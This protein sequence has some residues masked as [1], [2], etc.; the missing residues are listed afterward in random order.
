MNK[1]FKMLCVASGLL[2]STMLGASMITTAVAAQE[3]E[4][5]NIVRAFIMYVNHGEGKEFYEGMKAYNACYKENGGKDSW[6]AWTPQSGMMNVVAFRMPGLGWSAFDKDDDEAGKAC[7]ETFREKVVTHT[8]GIGSE[9]YNIW[10]DL[11]QTGDGEFNVVRVTN[12]DVDSVSKARELLKDFRQVPRPEGEPGIVW[13]GHR[14]GSDKWDFSLAYLFEN[15]AHMNPSEGLNFRERV[16]AHHGKEKADK[17]FK[18]WNKNVREA[19]SNI[20]KRSNDMSY[21]PAE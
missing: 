21:T 8:K 17:M 10:E 18:A 20:W 4:K 9:F 16:E 15:F 12:F 19:S 5:T 1:S 13:Q 6:T 7:Q 14:T 3:A 2:G 11:S